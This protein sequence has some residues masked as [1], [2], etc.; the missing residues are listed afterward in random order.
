MDKE[1]QDRVRVVV[2][3]IL[4]EADMK[5]VSEKQV[6]E[7]AS[8]KIGIDLSASR[9][10][11]KFVLNV[12]KKFMES[13]IDASDAEA[14]ESKTSPEEDRRNMSR[15]SKKVKTNLPCT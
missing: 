1:E 11:R 8:K 15:S 2:E 5:Q 13:E 6:R 3:K 14:D 7:L 4:A 9:E 12:I 10:W